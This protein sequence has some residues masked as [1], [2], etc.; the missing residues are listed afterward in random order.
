[1]PS[2]TDDEGTAAEIELAKSKKKSDSLKKAAEDF[3]KIWEDSMTKYNLN[4]TAENKQAMTDASTDYINAESKAKED[5]N[6]G[7]TIIELDDAAN[8]LLIWLVCVIGG[9]ILLICCCVYFCCM[10]K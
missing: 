1:M 8:A 5:E 6:S 3:K 10:R 4:P 9:T 2:N 7:V